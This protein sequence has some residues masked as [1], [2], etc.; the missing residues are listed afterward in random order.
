M[1]QLLQQGQVIIVPPFLSL[2]AVAAMRSS[3]LRVAGAAHTLHVHGFT[4]LLGLVSMRAC[5]SA[6]H[7]RPLHS[8]LQTSQDATWFV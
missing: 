7:A 1:W 5:M 8:L 4:H 6:S 3:S 2:H